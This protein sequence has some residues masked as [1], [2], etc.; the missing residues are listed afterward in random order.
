MEKDPVSFKGVHGD[1]GLTCRGLFENFSLKRNGVFTKDQPLLLCRR[2]GRH[3][4][5]KIL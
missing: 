4:P 3:R 1:T 5:K 2:I